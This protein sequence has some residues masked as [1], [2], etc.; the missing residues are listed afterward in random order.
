VQCCSDCGSVNKSQTSCE[1]AGN[2]KRPS[3]FIYQFHR[4]RMIQARSL[5]LYRS[6]PWH[7]ALFPSLIVDFHIFGSRIEI[8]CVTCVRS[9]LLCSDMSNVPWCQISFWNI[10]TMTFGYANPSIWQQFI[11]FGA[12]AYGAERGRA[13]GSG[14][15]KSQLSETSFRRT[16]SKT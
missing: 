6:L 3:I 7:F 8:C 5:H 14:A 12:L 11:N 15:P 4:H 10:A 2:M 1:G 9:R 13:N 16:S